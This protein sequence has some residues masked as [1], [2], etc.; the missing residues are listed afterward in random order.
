MLLAYGREKRAI[1]LLE[2]A[3][4][5]EPTREDLRIRLT[6]LRLPADQRPS[7]L[8]SPS[9]R[10][11][12][13]FW[14]VIA[15]LGV[16]GC[17]LGFAMYAKD[18]FLAYSAMSWPRSDGRVV[19]SQ[20]VQGCGGGRS[21]LPRVRFEYSVNGVTY[22]GERVA[23]GNPG[24]GSFEHAQSIAAR[25]PAGAAVPVYYEPRNPN[26]AVLL[27]GEVLSDTWL[28]L[29]GTLFFAVSLIWISSKAHSDLRRMRPMP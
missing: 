21:F 16:I 3:I 11:K 15:P 14:A 20:T 23:F 26:E 1:R 27:V 24:C 17:L 12:L 28:G 4:K 2:D 13:R 6:Q 9:E 10:F 8:V 25:F 22:D 5:A 19:S 18:V 7:P 29:A